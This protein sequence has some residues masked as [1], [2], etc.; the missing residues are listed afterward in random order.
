MPAPQADPTC[1]V[2]LKPVKPGSLVVYRHGEM[3]HVR[4]VTDSFA[5]SRATQQADLAAELLE[6]MTRFP[7][8]AVCHER[9]RG[10][11]LRREDGQAVHVSC[12]KG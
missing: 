1:P 2:C 4:C 3:V 11:Y 6:Q 12:P 9:I 7:T 8:C 5:D 10:D